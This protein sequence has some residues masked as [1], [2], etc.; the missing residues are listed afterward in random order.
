MRTAAAG[1]RPVH[2]QGSTERIARDIENRVALRREG[3]VDPEKKPT[4]NMRPFP[5]TFT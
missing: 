3:V 5:W 1:R 2:R 4:R